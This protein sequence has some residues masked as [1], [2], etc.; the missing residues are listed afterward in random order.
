MIDLGENTPFLHRYP[1]RGWFRADSGILYGGIRRQTT[2][3][4][5]SQSLLDRVECLSWCEC[6]RH[7]L[8][9]NTGSSFQTPWL[10]WKPLKRPASAVRSR[11][12]PP[13]IINNLQDS[14]KSLRSTEALLVSF[15]LFIFNYLGCRRGYGRKKAGVADSGTVCCTFK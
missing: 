4:S 13:F 14:A 1:G 12:W 15:N 8:K 10:D 9:L 6:F 3:E 5:K 2:I 11:L 7:N